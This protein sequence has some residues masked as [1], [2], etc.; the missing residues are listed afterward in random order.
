MVNNPATSPLKEHREW[1]K[2]RHKEHSFK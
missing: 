2:R 1:G